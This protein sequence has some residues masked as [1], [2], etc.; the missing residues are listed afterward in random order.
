M[1]TQAAAREY[2]LRGW[3]PVPVPRGSK[4]P[5]IKGWQN[6][7]LA[8]GDV[9]KYFKNDANVGLLV[10]E[11][12]KGLIDV[13]LDCIEAAR[14]VASF[15]P[16]ATMKSGRG[17]RPGTHWWYIATGVIPST[18]SF[19]DPVSGE[20]L[21]ELRS[22]GAQTLVAPSVHPEGD[23]Y[24]WSGDREPASIEGSDIE[25][26]VARLASATLLTRHWPT[27]DGS[28]HRISDVPLPS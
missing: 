17:T 14:L 22:T 7:R 1:G 19:V 20:M 11:P 23:N 24:I 15:M 6:L 10:G 27:V 8:A 16:N 28:R 9:T 18:R 12:S 4:A 2:V 21:V 26:Y 13:D 5:A 3:S 25:R